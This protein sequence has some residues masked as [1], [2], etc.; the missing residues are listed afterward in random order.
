MKFNL[1]QLIT[2]VNVSIDNSNNN[3]SKLKSDILSMDGMSG[4]KTRHLYNNI[5]SLDGANYLKIG[6]WKGSSFISALYGNNIS[7]IAIDNWS[8]FN[9]PKDQFIL[10][11]NKF[12]PGR[13]FKFIEK[14]CFKI[15]DN[16]IK[17]VY[18]SID[19]FLYDGAHD[20]ESQR[21]AITYYKHFF[22]NM[23]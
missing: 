10:N 2:R 18:E 13:K 12:C 19:I 6:T 15:T 14:D 7:A 8:E 3:I 23:L 4:N 16:E 22:Q 11:V 9:G 5:C 17:S 1:E 20:Y 21:K